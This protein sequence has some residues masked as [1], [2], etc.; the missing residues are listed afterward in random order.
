MYLDE[1]KVAI[2]VCHSQLALNLLFLIF[3]N[4][5]PKLNLR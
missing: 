1:N 2:M 4:R 5:N 3:A